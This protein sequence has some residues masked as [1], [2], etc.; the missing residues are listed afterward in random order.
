MYLDMPLLNRIRNHQL[1]Q[2]DFTWRF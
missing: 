2:A 1:V